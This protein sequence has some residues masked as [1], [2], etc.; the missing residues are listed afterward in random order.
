MLAQSLLMID[1]SRREGVKH[2]VIELFPPFVLE[3]LLT[4]D[5]EFRVTATTKKKEVEVMKGVIRKGEKVNVHTFSDDKAINAAIRIP[6]ITG[7]SFRALIHELFASGFMWTEP[8]PIK[9]NVPD[10]VDLKDK[11][12]RPLRIHAEEKMR[13]SSVH[14]ISF[15]CDY[16]LINK[17]GLRLLYKQESTLSNLP[18]AAGQYSNSSHYARRKEDKLLKG[19]S[20]LATLGGSL[21]VCY[22]LISVPVY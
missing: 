6:G 12:K 4:D 21:S 1:T 20:V 5:M 19:S 18:L 17:T 16:W 10:L 11:E 7:V 13:R 8:I 9:N 3:N 22:S 15:W 14:M 2:H